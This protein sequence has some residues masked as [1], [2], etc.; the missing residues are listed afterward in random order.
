MALYL[1]VRY[2]YEAASSNL[3]KQHQYVQKLTPKSLSVLPQ[4]LLTQLHQAAT[5]GDDQKA[6]QL[7][8]Q[9]PQSQSPLKAELVRLVEELRLDTISDLTH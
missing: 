3:Q 7:I 8:E 9:I 5:L 6:K 2:I 4:E 1:G